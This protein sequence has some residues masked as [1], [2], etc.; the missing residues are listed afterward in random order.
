MTSDTAGEPGTRRP[1][2]R[3]LGTEDAT[4]LEFWVA[5]SAGSHLQLDDV[6]A[7]ARQLPDGRTG[8]HLRRGD[9]GPGPPRGRHFDSDVFLHQPTA[10]LPAEVQ[11]AAEMTTTRVEPEVFVPPLPGRR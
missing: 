3:V 4:P 8:H 7:T 2:G 10:L 1:T 11:E 9:R 5:V 6:V